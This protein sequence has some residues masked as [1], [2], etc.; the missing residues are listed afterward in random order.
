MCRYAFNIM[1]GKAVWNTTLGFGHLWS[2]PYVDAGKVYIGSDDGHLFVL[3][4]TTGKQAWNFTAPESVRAA[5]VSNGLV[6]FGTNSHM[7]PGS[8]DQLFALETA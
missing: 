1:T 7:S 3:D 4:A 6:Y 5:V 8:E 2:F